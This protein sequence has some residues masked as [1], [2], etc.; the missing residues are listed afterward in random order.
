VALRVAS[1]MRSQRSRANSQ[2]T[3]AAIQSTVLLPEEATFAVAERELVAKLDLAL[4]RLPAKLRAPLV[5]CY[6]EGK[7][8]QEAARELGLP[9]GS[10]SRHLARGLELLRERLASRELLLSTDALAGLLARGVWRVLVDRSLAETTT[11]AALCYAMGALAAGGAAS[12]RVLT[13]SQG[14]T[15][16]M[17]FTQL[18]ALIGLVFAAG[19]LGT[20]GYWQIRQQ[21]V[22]QLAEFAVESD[23]ETSVNPDDSVAPAMVSQEKLPTTSFSTKRSMHESIQIKL[24]QPVVLDKGLEPMTFGDAKQ[25]FEDRFATQI[26]VSP[27]LMNNEGNVLEAQV[28]LDKLVGIPLRDVLEMLAG[29]FGAT[30]LV[31]PNYVEI[32]SLEMAQPEAWIAGERRVVPQ[33]HANFQDTSL[34]R[35][36]RELALETGITV[37][38]DKGAFDNAGSPKVT[39]FFDG[40]R[41]DTAVELLAN[42]C[43]MKAVALDRALYVTSNLKA[44]ELI[45]EREARRLARAKREEKKLKDQERAEAK[46]NKV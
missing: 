39:A 42:M 8:H 7:S 30:Y 1:K 37:V 12:V 28:K 17:M 9:P 36:L 19:I 10:M 25:Y 21:G 45:K 43:G 20:G 32:V 33:V 24:D 3:G 22:G 41:L 44:A 46:K 26:L 34:D 2:E 15:R 38:L 16:A 14:V 11:R 40:T 27:G 4:Q 35:A 31:H 5:L 6:L 29:Q 18:K 23:A 13:L